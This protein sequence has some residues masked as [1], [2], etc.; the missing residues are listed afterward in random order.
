MRF[1]TPPTLSGQPEQKIEQLTR[2]LFRMSEMLNVA[3]N[4]IGNV[5]RV[6]PAADPSAIVMTTPGGVSMPS[7]EY[8]ELKALIINT[9]SVAKKTADSLSAELHSQYTAI[10]ED[11]GTFQ[12]NINNTIE[13]TAEGVVQ[14]FG[15]DAAIETLQEDAA[16]FSEYV[17]KSEGYIRQGFID[18]DANGV[19]IVGIAIGQTLKSTTVTIGDVE[20]Q[21][22]D[23]SQSCAF[24]TADRVSFRVNG[25]EVA[26]VSNSKLYI[27]DVEITGNVNLAGKWQVSTTGGLTIKWIGG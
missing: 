5:Q 3:M 25:L 18:K 12:E 26:Y 1:E 6:T 17:T 24:Y 10:S 9:A 8:E 27:R 2:Y 4:D 11:W 16:G 23:A 20:Y 13:A 21:Q 7:E 14:Q 19:P 15:Y 22:L